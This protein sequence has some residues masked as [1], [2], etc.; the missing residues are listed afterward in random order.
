MRRR[1]KA[2]PTCVAYLYFG[3]L[4]VSLLLHLMYRMREHAE[5]G[6]FD[7]FFFS[8]SRILHAT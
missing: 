1:V 3:S 7:I 4:K 6:D 8:E 5:E 2:D